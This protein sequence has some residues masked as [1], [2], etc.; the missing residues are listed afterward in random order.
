MNKCMN[1][2]QMLLIRYSVLEVS[3]W[4]ELTVQFRFLV[5]WGA[6]FE[7]IIVSFFRG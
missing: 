7:T 2:D 1:I 4:V 3:I 5:L 6:W